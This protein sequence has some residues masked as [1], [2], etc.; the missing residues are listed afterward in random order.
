MALEVAKDYERV[1]FVCKASARMDILR[2][3]KAHG[4]FKL[5]V[6]SYNK[7]GDAS[8]LSTSPF[9]L[10]IFDECHMMANWKPA[11][12]QRMTRIKDKKFLFMSG[13]PMNKSEKDLLYVL[14]KVGAFDD[15][16]M[17]EVKVRYFNAQVTQFSKYPVCGKFQNE[18]EFYDRIDD[19]II[20]INKR[21]VDRDIPPVNVIIEKLEGEH[22]SFK[23]IT[24]CTE[25]RLKTG[26]S[27]VI[28]VSRAIR[29]YIR[30]NYINTAV[31]HTHFHDVA[32]A[33]GKELSVPVA[34]TKEKVDKEFERI[35]QKGGF[36]VTTLGLTQS[37]LDLNECDW[38]FMVEMN[39]SAAMD[40]Q[41]IDRYNRVGKRSVLNVVYFPYEAEHTFFK[42]RDTLHLLGGKKYDSSNRIYPSGLDAYRTCPGSF[43][44]PDVRNIPPF[45]TNA[46]V[47]GEKKHSIFERYMSSTE[48]IGKHTP[49]NVA[50]AIDFCKQLKEGLN[51]WGVE[52]RCKYE[53][54]GYV[55]SGKVDFWCYDEKEK[56]L[57]IFD[58]KNGNTKVK[59]EG[60]KQL[61][62]YAV[63]LCETFKFA[64]DKVSVGILQGGEADVV[65]L[66][67][68]LAAPRVRAIIKQID[69]AKSSPLDFI[70]ENCKNIFCKCANIK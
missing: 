52:T 2:K 23:D 15:M 36:L 28:P 54:R 58:Y 13:T 35:R 5:E 30:N 53:Y 45:I 57:A 40:K 31:I 4:A 27:K 55:L 47:V 24:E 26:M 56:H 37:S 38:C 14:R 10:I 49:D 41:T 20:T 33:L 19:Y 51:T 17:E 3:A 64:P 1:L 43:W 16:T 48:K 25:A 61:E 44:L 66:D 70:D 18:D 67:F 21:D 12:T 29:N 22:E 34:L 68:N 46:A 60:N 50:H 65:E 42:N 32:T 9:D 8:K 69:R 59:A 62:A 63:M 11:Y 39:Y 6:C 7:F